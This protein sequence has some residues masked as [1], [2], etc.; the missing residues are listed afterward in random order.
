MADMKRPACD[1]GYGNV[2]VGQGCGA[3]TDERNCGMITSK[4]K[5]TNPENTCSSTTS[6]TMNLTKSTWG[7]NIVVEWSQLI[8]CIR[9][10]L[11][12]NLGPQT[13]HP[14]L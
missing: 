4:G 8:L 11:S 3:A 13:S 12:S 14:K 5:P 10:V 9:K 1:P 6:S 2:L 7:P